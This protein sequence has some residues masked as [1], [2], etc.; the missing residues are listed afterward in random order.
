MINLTSLY[1]LLV[2]I[3]LSNIISFYFIKQ[4]SGRQGIQGPIGDKGNIGSQGE[5]G[6]R[7]FTGIKGPTGFSGKEKGLIGKKGIIGPK[8]NQGIEGP[9][10]DKGLRGK[11]GIKG[12]QG[13][14]GIDGKQG[15]KGRKGLQGITRVGDTQNN[16]LPLIALKDKCII[17]DTLRC[18]SNMA[19]FDMNASV[20][21]S[22]KSKIDTITCCK[23]GLKNHLLSSYYNLADEK[24]NIG[25]ELSNY[26]S[27]SNET[28]KKNAKEIFLILMKPY[29]YPPYVIHIIRLLSKI[30][31]ID[32]SKFQDE[33]IKFPNND[34]YKLEKYIDNL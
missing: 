28:L 30:Y 27:S 19:V 17:T 25:A 8:G 4:K 7:G 31:K 29:M 3:V 14:S 13:D 2:I 22:T 11:S 24:S 9:L 1:S 34:I 33:I 21:D 26:S 12:L 20:V 23:I 15:N 6:K 5:I 16:D 18:P 10:G 32:T